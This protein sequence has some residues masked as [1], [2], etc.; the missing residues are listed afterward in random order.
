MGDF[1]RSPKVNSNQGGRDHWN[2]CYTIMLAGGGIRGGRVI[3][4]TDPEGGKK[5]KDPRQVQ[6][7]HATALTALGINTAK[8]N[9]SHV[10]RPIKISEGKVIRA[11]LVGK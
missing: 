9:I 2:S 6:E 4:Q 3:G 8:E 11:L 10:G 5:V 7:I 1:G